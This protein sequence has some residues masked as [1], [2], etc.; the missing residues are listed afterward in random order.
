MRQCPEFHI[1]Q[2]QIM[3]CYFISGL[4]RYKGARQLK[5]ASSSSEYDTAT[6]KM[7]TL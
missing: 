6:R 3:Q 5:F 2:L 4:T 7:S 1:H